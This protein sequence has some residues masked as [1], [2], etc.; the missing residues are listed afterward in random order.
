MG[1]FSGLLLLPLAPVRGVEW[2]SSVVLDAAERELYDPA[3]LRAQLVALNRAYDDGE[4]DDDT[5]EREEERLLDLL[6][7]PRRDA[8]TPS[9]SRGTR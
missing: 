6:E 1:L 9:Y 8:R 4:V 3:V 2:L 5:F 7:A